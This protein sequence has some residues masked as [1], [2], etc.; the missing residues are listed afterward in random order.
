MEMMGGMM[1]GAFG[2]VGSI[3]GA[4]IAADAQKYTAN[5]NWSIAL[6]NYY[7][8]EREKYQAQ[9]EASRIEAKQDLGMTDAKGNT[10]KFVPGVGWV[11]ELAPAQ[12]ALQA[13]EDSERMAQYGDL[14]KQRRHKD[15]NLAQ[16]AKE[17]DKAS[18]LFDEMKSQSAPTATTLENLISDAQGTGINRAFDDTAKIASRQALRTGTNPSGILS[19]IARQRGKELG[20]VRGAARTQAMTLAPQLEDQENKMEANLYNLFA[21]RASASPEASFSPVGI[22]TGGLSQAAGRDQSAGLKAAMMEGGRL[23]YQPVNYGMA[24]LAGAIGAAG[25]GFMKNASPYMQQGQF[26]DG[27]GN[28]WDTFSDRER[29]RSGYGSFAGAP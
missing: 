23:P 18:A 24:N 2:A 22:D 19:E 10:T 15:L 11:Q 13:R 28:L 14:A 9:I 20:G 5:T 16:Q 7:A 6:M 17:R 1:G 3:V 12:K 25:Q 29:N 21:T 27:G 26:G 4:S 8:R